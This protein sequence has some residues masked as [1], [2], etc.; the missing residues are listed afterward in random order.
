MAGIRAHLARI[1]LAWLVL[2]VC[3]LGA[4]SLRLS[5]TA[6]DMSGTTCTC[7]HGDG[8]ACPMHGDRS[9]SD[10]PPAR[11]CSYRS[12]SDPLAVLAS[13]LIGP[14]AVVPSVSSTSIPVDRGAR[15]PASQ[16]EPLDVSFVPD[17]PPPRA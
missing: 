17:S 8:K 12:A 3:F 15:L 11:S 7:P 9:K 14:A 13:S 16:S 4:V 2:D 1:A 6:F 10:A 5:S